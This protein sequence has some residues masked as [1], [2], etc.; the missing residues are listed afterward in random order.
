MTTEDYLRAAENACASAG[1]TLGC[2]RRALARRSWRTIVARP[3]HFGPLVDLGADEL[4]RLDLEGEG[5]ATPRRVR[6]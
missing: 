5:V 6:R 1:A 2:A 4:D 3:A